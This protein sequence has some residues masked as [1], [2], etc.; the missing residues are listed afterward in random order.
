M[1]I[2]PTARE[3]QYNELLTTF[4]TAQ[5]QSETA[6]VAAQLFPFLPTTKPSGTFFKYPKRYWLNAGAKKRAPGTE[7][8]GG[9]FHLDTG[10]FNVEIYAY[11]SDLADPIRDG[12]ADVLDLERDHTSIVTSN[13]L[14]TRELKFQTTFLKTGVWQGHRVS[15]AVADFTPSVLWSADNSD[16]I[17]DIALLQSEIA[18][19]TGIRPNAMAIT[20]DVM[21]RLINHPNIVERIKYTSDQS[22]TP[23][24][25]ARM[26]NVDKFLPM[27]AVYDVAAEGQVSTPGFMTKNKFL[28]VHSAPRPGLMTATA[29]MTFGWTGYNG[30]NA[31]GATISSFRLNQ[32][33][34]TRYEGEMAYDMQ[35][36]A[37]DLGVLGTGLLA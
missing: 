13:L 8:A 32:L 7:S 6:Y 26:F 36:I 16:P 11:H 25:L 1:P 17:S 4:S 22:V 27:Q 30:A 20:D 37:P 35:I 3:S 2:M 29:G 21:N 18:G 34:S 14:L 31:A 19:S 24:I 12:A 5:I 10:T 28:L 23:A 33:R 9:G 15:G